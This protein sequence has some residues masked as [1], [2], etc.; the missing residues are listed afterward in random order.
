MQQRRARS[1]ESKL[2]INSKH[3]NVLPIRGSLVANPD[4]QRSSSPTNSGIS[5]YNLSAG[6]RLDDDD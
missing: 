3:E 4:F 6:Y 2:K 1:R 5:F